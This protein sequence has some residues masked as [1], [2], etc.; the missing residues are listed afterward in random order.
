MCLQSKKGRGK[1]DHGDTDADNDV[2]DELS[3][4]IKALSVG[5]EAVEQSPPETTAKVS[6]K[7][8]RRQE[9]TDKA[10]ED[11][12]AVAVA[13]EKARLD[14]DKSSRKA[15]KKAVKS[16]TG[17]EEGEDEG[18]DHGDEGGG[19]KKRSSKKERKKSKQEV[20]TV[21]HSRVFC[22][23]LC[24]LW[25]S[26]RLPCFQC[27]VGH[28]VCAIEQLIRTDKTT[29]MFLDDAS[30]CQE[31][32][33]GRRRARVDTLG[34]VGTSVSWAAFAAALIECCDNGERT[35]CY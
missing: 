4:G 29:S 25:I 32:G 13:E 1:D 34:Y 2:E 9:G 11:T 5:G 22:G 3:R 31:K 16:K 26:D 7:E 20:L 14:E 8:H 18:H 33:R 28:G 17:M 12:E 6:K 19:Q 30:G 27:L 23:C 24:M 21:V 35:G 15:S 10:G